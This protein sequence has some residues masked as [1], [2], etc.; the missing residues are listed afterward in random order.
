MATVDIDLGK[1][2]LGWSDSE[3]DYVFKPERGLNEEIIRQM[4]AM[5]KEPEWMLDFRLK[6]YQRFLRKPIP[7]WGGGGMLDTIDFDNIYY[8]IKPT[9]EQAAPW[10]MVPDSIKETYEKL[11]I[12]EA[13]RKYL[14]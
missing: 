8:Y 3:A 10:D 11:G 1:Y 14:A 4:S 7:D 6:S 12:R 5:K 13:E 2:Q 9:E